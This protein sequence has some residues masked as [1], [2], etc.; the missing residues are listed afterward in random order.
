MGCPGT[1]SFSRILVCILT[2]AS[3]VPAVAG[4]VRLGVAANFTHTTREL[5]KRFEEQTGYS[6]TASFGS[7]GKLY[8]QII[9]G[10]PYDIFMAADA[11][12]PKLIEDEQAGVAGSRFTFA[13]GQLAFWRPDD[14]GSDPKTY[15]DRQTFQR[16]A[17]ANPKTAPYGLAAKQVLVNLGHW[18]RL[19]GKVVRGESIAQTFQFVV[20]G[21]AQAGFVALSQIRNWDSS[22]GHTWLVPQDYY[23]PIDQQ[24]ILLNAGEGRAGAEA[25]MDFLKSGDA[26]SIIQ[27][28]GYE[29]GDPGDE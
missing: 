26:V 7:T 14:D 8:A 13:R 6:V 18:S 1:F 24:A 10:A 5:V 15:L 11:H 9:N 20:S 16:L 29:I 3:A 4:D 23:Q 2:L 12:R 17:I 22:E 27:S 19:E 28:H 21:N 25:W